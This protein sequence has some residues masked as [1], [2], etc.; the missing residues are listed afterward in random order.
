MVAHRA[1]P[2]W[3]HLGLQGRCSLAGAA[4]RPRFRYFGGSVV[5]TAHAAAWHSRS[6]LL[7]RSLRDHGLG[8]DHETGN[9]RGVLQGGRLTSQ[10][11]DLTVCRI[12]LR[13]RRLSGN[14]VALLTSRAALLPRAAQGAF[15]E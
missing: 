5:H 13:G 12:R 6:L 10:P 14:V 7:L 3:A 9:G 8:R 2:R 4:M 1:A 15:C 11:R